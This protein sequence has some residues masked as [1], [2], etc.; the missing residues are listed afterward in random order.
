MSSLIIDQAF[1]FVRH[2]PSLCPAFD[3]KIVDDFQGHFSDQLVVAGLSCHSATPGNIFWTSVR[4]RSQPCRYAIRSYWPCRSEHNLSCDR[5]TIG[6]R[7]KNHPSSRQTSPECNQAV[8]SASDR[9]VKQITSFFV[10][11]TGGV[12]WALIEAGEKCGFQ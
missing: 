4:S 12:G 9:D 1:Q 5:S 8:P 7:A 6:Q 11:M 3:T 10:L 2:R